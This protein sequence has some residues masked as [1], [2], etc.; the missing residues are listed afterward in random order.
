MRLCSASSRGALLE[1]ARS[2]I[3]CSSATGLLSQLAPQH[4]IELAEQARRVGVPAP[5]QVLRER[6]EPLVR[7][8]D[9][10]PEGPGLADDRRELRR[11]PRQTH[12]TSSA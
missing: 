5:P 3:C 9:E 12:A 11:R 1:S 10:L 6:A 4:R 2:D 7:R 8:R